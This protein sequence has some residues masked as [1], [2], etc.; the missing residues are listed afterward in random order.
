M[1]L[2]LSRVRARTCQQKVTARRTITVQC[3][4]WFV[5]QV[6]HDRTLGLFWMTFVKPWSGK[7]EGKVKRWI[8][9]C[10]VSYTRSAAC[11]LNSFM[12][13]QYIPYIRW[14]IDSLKYVAVFAKYKWKTFLFKFCIEQFLL[15]LF[16][17][18]WLLPQCFYVFLWKQQSHFE[19]SIL[20]I[21]NVCA[22]A[23]SDECDYSKLNSLSILYDMFMI[24]L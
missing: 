1:C 13:R 4:C 23:F 9:F 10:A 6:I 24:S 17:L 19:N 8:L 22:S 14:F 5:K 16:L 7:P 18:P 12:I 15:Y 21:T 2:K 3:M 20:I 11:M